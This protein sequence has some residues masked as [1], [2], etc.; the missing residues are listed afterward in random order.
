[1]KRLLSACAGMLLAAGI[2][3]PANAQYWGI[4]SGHANHGRHHDDLEHRSYHRELDHRSAHRYPMTHR[5]HGQLH[6]DLDHEEFHDDLEHRGAHRYNAYAPRY[7]Y[8]GHGYYG[9]FPSGHH[10]YRSYHSGSGFRLSSPGF[11]IRIGR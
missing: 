6:D 9:H 8:Y 4:P 11:S 10:P 5:Q 2:A 3:A 7:R 1:M